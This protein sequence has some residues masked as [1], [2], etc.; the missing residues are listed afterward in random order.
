MFNELIKDALKRQGYVS[1]GQI[2]DTWLTLF[3]DQPELIKL[4]KEVLRAWGKDKG[5][6]MGSKP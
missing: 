6:F 4:I 3:V 2:D 5:A 1:M